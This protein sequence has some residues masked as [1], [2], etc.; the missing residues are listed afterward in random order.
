MRCSRT[1][2]Y[3]L[4]IR[5]NRIFSEFAKL[6]RTRKRFGSPGT[7]VDFQRRYCGQDLEVVKKFYHFQSDRLKSGKGRTSH[8]F[9]PFSGAA[10]RRDV[11]SRRHSRRPCRTCAH[12][13]PG[14]RGARTR[15]FRDRRL[16]RLSS[17][18]VGRGVAGNDGSGFG[19]YEVLFGPRRPGGAARGGH[20][21]CRRRDPAG[22][23]GC[24]RRLENVA[25]SGGRLQEPHGARA[26]GCHQFAHFRRGFRRRLLLRAGPLFAARLH[27][28]R[29]YRHEFGRRA[30]PEIR[31]DDQQL[32]RC[33]NGAS[34]WHGHRIGRKTSRR[35]R[36]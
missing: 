14:D 2:Y 34:R 29:Q 28:R 3:L 22:R 15:A 19:G 33:D 4:Q 9:D 32:A 10:R 36:L 35:G 7:R 27:D 16:H 24:H 21:A 20:I 17:Y 30:L 6:L 25:H 1:T 31:C 8:E 18:T 23:R 13:L 26:G 11:S 5:P 12:R